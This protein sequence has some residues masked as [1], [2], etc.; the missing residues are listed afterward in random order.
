[1]KP[2][3]KLLRNRL[4]HL[5]MFISP[6]CFCGCCGRIIFKVSVLECPYCEFPGYF[7]WTA[8]FDNRKDLR[9]FIKRNI[10]ELYVS[11]KTSIPIASEK[12]PICL[13]ELI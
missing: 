13:G 11:S 5:S 6:K 2:L 3:I 8:L 10:D 9:R 4:K 12:I 1:M 7:K